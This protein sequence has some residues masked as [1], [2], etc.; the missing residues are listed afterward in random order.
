MRK[1]IVSLPFLVTKC[2]ITFLL[3]NPISQKSTWKTNVITSATR[4]HFLN[5]YLRAADV[6]TLWEVVYS[7]QIGLYLSV[8]SHTKY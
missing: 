2:V 6:T 4:Q 8:N 5:K 7:I 3:Y 1:K